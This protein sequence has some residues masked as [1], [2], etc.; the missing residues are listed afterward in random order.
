M[1]KFFVTPEQLELDTIILTGENAAHGKVLRLRIGE[2]VL[3]CDQQGNECV[4]TITNTDAGRIE[5]SV[6]DRRQSQSEPKVKVT[7]YMAF[8]KGDKLEH[9][10]QKSTELGACEIVAFPSA[11]CISKPDAKSITKKL[12]RWNKIAES[13]A[14]QSGRGYVPKVTTASS[15]KEVLVNAHCSSKG[16]LCFFES[17]VA[18]SL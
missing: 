9:V 17:A 4:C 16:K 12:D 7:V 10:I 13:A 2:D 18:V 3:V 1:T 6:K 15:Y 14:E 8:P 5:L 11:R